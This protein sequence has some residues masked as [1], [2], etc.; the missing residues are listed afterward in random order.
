MVRR[1]AYLAI[2]S[3]VALL[4]VVM[5]A[6]LGYAELST[7]IASDTPLVVEVRQGETL[8]QFTRRL[9]EQ[10]ALQRP[11]LVTMLG[12]LR[13]DS[14][15]IKAGEYV[16]Q[17]RVSPSEL[18][19]Y[20]VSGQ[21]R[22][23]ALTVPEGF[24]LAEIAERLEER[25]LGRADVFLTLTHD[26]GFIA[27]LH[28]PVEP[29]PHSLEGFLY[30]D[31]YFFYRGA[32]EA[33]L[34][35]AMVSEFRKRALEPLLQQ[36]GAVGMNPYQ[37]LIL[38]SIVEKETAVPGERELIAAVF[39]NRLRARMR[40]G[41]DPTVI[42]G[43]QSFDGNLRRVDLLTETPY[44]TYKILGLPPTP[45]ANPGQDSIRAAVAPAKVDYLFFVAK[46]DGTHVFSKDYRTHSRA[47]W[48]YQI[49]PHRKRNS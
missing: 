9:G 40:L 48:K 23:A 18:L 19:D 25:A 10:G 16:L 7:T 17:G 47:V 36:A 33:S 21:A 34:I 39:H 15:N 22:Y 1:P 20:L 29:A 30:P 42:Y 6:L 35:T 2:G 44:N 26:P 11:R 12:I 28:L 8:R 46:G 3:A 37:A 13:G 43:L 45:I 14:A 27:S 38:A 49:R 31:T 5:A 24:N 41:S 4:A 32:S